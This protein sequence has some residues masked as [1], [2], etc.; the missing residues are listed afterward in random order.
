MNRLL[1]INIRFGSG[2]EKLDLPG[3]DLHSSP[4]NLDAIA[5]AIDSIEPDVVALQEVRGSPKQKRSRVN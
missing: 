5:A 1:T 2:C 3:Y 4:K